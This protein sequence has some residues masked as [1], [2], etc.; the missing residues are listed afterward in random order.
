[1][2]GRQDQ[3]S[4][5]GP[6]RE[7]DDDSALWIAAAR[8]PTRASDEL[9]LVGADVAARGGGVQA[10]WMLA[11]AHSSTSLNAIRQLLG[12]RSLHTTSVYLQ[13]IG[14]AAAVAEATAKTAH[15]A[16]QP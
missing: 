7:P 9:L 3:Q 13:H 16:V 15:L 4:T 11:P 2:Y 5:A 8:C 1:M 12:Y 6:V 14:P 10:R